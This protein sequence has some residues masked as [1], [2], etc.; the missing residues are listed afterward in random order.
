MSVLA[1]PGDDAGDALG[2]VAVEAG[3][4]HVILQFQR[5]MVLY[6]A[7]FERYE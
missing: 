6:C 7:L 5:I 4:C 2:E 3:H 1:V